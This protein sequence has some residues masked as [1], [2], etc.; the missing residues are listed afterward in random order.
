M[1]SKFRQS[2]AA[3]VLS[4]VLALGTTVPAVAGGIPTYDGA[5]VAQAIKQGVQMKQQ[6]DNQLDQIKQL[7]EQ[8]KALTGSRNLGQ[9]AKN[10]LLNQVPDEWK[11][12]YRDIKDKNYKSLTDKSAYKTDGHRQSLVDTYNHAYEAIVNTQ[13]RVKELNDLMRQINLTQ[14]AKAAADLQ[15]RIA[16]TQGQIANSQ[17]AL[18]LADRLAKQEEKI[19][20]AQQQNIISCQI[21]AKSKA[22][23]KAC[24][25]I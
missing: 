22:D 23:R 9:I 10:D 20:A 19:R 17:V 16:I 25:T 18:D 14:D 1:K 4:A 5:A 6:I 8:V 15:N 2:A 7:K 13:T 3:A 24:G 11:G 12:I 21:T